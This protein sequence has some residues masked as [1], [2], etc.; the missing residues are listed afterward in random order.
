LRIGSG[1]A[2]GK[3][4]VIIS[5]SLASATGKNAGDTITV[6]YV[7]KYDTK[8]VETGYSVS[9][10]IPYNGVLPSEAVL[11]NNAQFIKMYNRNIPDN[12]N[13]DVAFVQDTQHVLYPLL[14][15]E[16]TLMPRAKSTTELSKLQ[17]EIGKSRTPGTTMDIRTMYESASA[18]LNL[19]YVLNMITFIAVMVLFF[20]ILIGVINTLRMTVKERTREIGTVR[21]IGM[22]KRDVQLSF[23]LET[24]FLSLFSAIAGTIVAL[25]TMVILSQF[26]IDAS[27]NALSMLLVNDR[28][29]FVPTA[30]HVIF[31]ILLIICI[32][33][34]TA[35]FPARKAANLSAAEALRHFE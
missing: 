13:T 34:A 6:S 11:I 14:V 28:L 31:Y 27:E 7:S 20:I 5:D 1:D 32:A 10:V 19:E 26:K 3:D 24:F 16:W 33:V 8:V 18:V 22:Q 25:I 30:L 23:V 9:T 2:I 12:K 4:A 29:Y 35:Y 15:P 21:A 17:K